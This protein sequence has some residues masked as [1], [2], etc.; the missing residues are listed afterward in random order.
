MPVSLMKYQVNSRGCDPQ[1]DPGL[2][3]SL[4]INFSPGDWRDREDKERLVESAGEGGD[5]PVEGSGFNQPMAKRLQPRPALGRKQ[6]KVWFL[7]V[8]S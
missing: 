6:N 8:V 5:L 7:L 1:K 2:G 4:R 3:V